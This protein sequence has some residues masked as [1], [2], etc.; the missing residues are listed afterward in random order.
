MDIKGKTV[1]V[2]GANGGI[3]GALVS[4]LL[5]EGIAKV[6][7]AAR[8]TDTVADLVQGG[9]G[10]V[11]ALRLD[12][13][14]SASVHGAAEQCRDVDLVINNAGINRCTG[15][16][17]SSAMEDARLEMEVNYFGTLAMCRAFAPVLASRGGG[18]IV[19]VCSII[20]LVNLP[21]NGTYCASKAA[22]H[23]LLQ[24]LRAELAPRGIRVIGVY[25]GPVDTKMTEGQEM[26]KATPDEVAA[27]ILAGVE[28]GD[29]YI[30]PDPMS[31]H[32][33]VMLE[34]DPRQVERDFG[35]MAGG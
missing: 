26:P 35:A 29:E 13:T 31:R 19:N 4:A 23:S 28:K 30:F 10:R 27:A 6:Y 5:D 21:V 3:G 17:G 7:A 34:K 9:G 2:T 32:V 18:A 20:G 22:G 15:F 24:G 14:Q 33:H 1:L 11:V 12:V 8:S 25:P 16:M